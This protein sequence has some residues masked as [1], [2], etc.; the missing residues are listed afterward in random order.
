MEIKWIE[1]DSDFGKMFSAKPFQSVAFF[2]VLIVND[3]RN[4][5]KKEK[6]FASEK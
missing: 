2:F 5:V 1:N 6:C 4:V 3:Q